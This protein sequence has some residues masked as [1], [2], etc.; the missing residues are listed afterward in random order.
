MLDAVHALL[1]IYLDV[2]PKL[3]V[4]HG[5]VYPAVLQEVVLQRLE[6]ACARVV[7]AQIS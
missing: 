6:Q 2:V 7:P 4:E 1:T 5:I 3:I